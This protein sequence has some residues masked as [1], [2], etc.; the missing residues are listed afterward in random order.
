LRTDR[1]ERG[2]VLSPDGRWIAYLSDE[3]GKEE[4]YVASFDVPSG[5]TVGAHGKWNVSQ[6]GG[7]S[8]RWPRDSKELFYTTPDGNLVAVDVGTLPV[9]RG[10]HRK[11]F[12]I[13]SNV[14]DVSPDG[15]RFLASV[16]SAKA[17]LAPFTVALNWNAALR[18]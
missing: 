11:L 13:G 7:V 4:V 9:F 15:K 1:V 3:S 18:K 17:S 8:V 6:E 2:A 16:P 5:G 10:A 14:W 12:R